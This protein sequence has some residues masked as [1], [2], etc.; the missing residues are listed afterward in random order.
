MLPLA[1]GER[2]L[3]LGKL[4]LDALDGGLVDLPRPP[5]GRTPVSESS[6]SANVTA[7]RSPKPV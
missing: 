7:S 6:V 1:L 2:D 4:D 5:H 3:G